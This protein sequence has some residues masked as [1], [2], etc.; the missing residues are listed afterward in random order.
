MGVELRKKEDNTTSWCKNIEEIF[1]QLFLFTEH[2]SE[3]WN[4]NQQGEEDIGQTIHKLSLCAR[5]SMFLLQ[6]RTAP[7]VNYEQPGWLTEKV[8]QR[9]LQNAKNKLEIGSHEEEFRDRLEKRLKLI[10]SIALEPDSEDED[11]QYHHS[12]QEFED[13]MDDGEGDN[14]EKWDYLSSI[15]WNSL[16]EEEQEK[17]QKTY[18]NVEKPNP[19]YMPYH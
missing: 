13:E 1:N 15:S 10:K 7:V 11:S 9:S 4:L 8:A 3:N 18:H 17:E 6:P 5:P 16:D 19:N 2:I 12:D 14:Q